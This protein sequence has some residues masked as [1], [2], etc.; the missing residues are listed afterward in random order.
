MLA[1]SRDVEEVKAGFALSRELL[2]QP[3]LARYA[4]CELFPGEQIA[5]DADLE[6][7]LRET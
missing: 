5:S 1:H 3:S 7:L 4:G 6:S 2:R